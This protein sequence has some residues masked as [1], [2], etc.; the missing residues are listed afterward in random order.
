M[1]KQPEQRGEIE[2]LV[3]GA[4]GGHV[5]GSTYRLN[6]K[7][8]GILV[9]YGM[10]QGKNDERSPRGERRNFTPTSSIAHGVTDVTLSHVHIDHSGNLPRLAKDGFKPRI[11]ATEITANFL[12]IMLKNSA[13]IQAGEHREN[14]LY[15]PEDVRN[16]MRCLRI[17]DPFTQIEVGQKHSRTTAE[18]VPNG[19][20]EGAS[21][22][23]FRIRGDKGKQNILFTGDMGKRGQSI[24]GGYEEYASYYP[25]EPVHSLVVESTNFLN[26]PI[27]FREKKDNLFREIRETWSEGGNP[28]L[29]VL[30]MHRFQEILEMLHND[31][32]ELEPHGNFQVVLDAPLAMKLLREFKRL[33]PDQLSRR[34]GDNPDYYRTDKESLSRFELKNCKIIETHD[35]SILAD[36]EYSDYRGRAIILAS[37]GMLDHGRSLIWYRGSFCRN[38]RNKII[39]TCFQVRGTIGE[40]LL[41]DQVVRDGNN[42]GARVKKVEGFTSHISGPEET[43]RFLNRFNLGKLQ[44]VIITHGGDQARKAM[45]EEFRRRGHSGKIYLPEIGE[46]IVLQ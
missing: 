46:R 23:F 29:P 16:I 39:L 24:C 15:S 19:H 35:E 10:F 5:T 31:G 18:F 38:P 21:S 3:Y 11:L 34:Y 44:T 14:R 25:Q 42:R 33:T 8:L 28:L 22:I 36:A 41:H 9:D 30:S 2:I 7:N 27:S 32:K 45:A 40:A 20:I 37:G 43:F 6:G 1:A 12:G 17:V 26:K 4:A 13:E